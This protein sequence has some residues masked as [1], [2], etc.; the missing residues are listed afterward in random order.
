MYSSIQDNMSTQK[1]TS[2]LLFSPQLWVMSPPKASQR[3]KMDVAGANLQPK[4]CSIHSDKENTLAS[5]AVSP[6][7]GTLSAQWDEIVETESG[8]MYSE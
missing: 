6:G 8:E 7:S 1:G 5:A 4:T 3:V 2:P